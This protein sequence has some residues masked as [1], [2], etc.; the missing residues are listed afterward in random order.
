MRAASTAGGA[1][2]LNVALA[3]ASRDQFTA[4]ACSAA[5]A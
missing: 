2:R 3:E 1:A 5:Y 4:S